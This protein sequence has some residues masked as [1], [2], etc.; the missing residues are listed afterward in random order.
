MPNP[1]PNHVT[2]DLEKRI[3]AIEALGDV[4]LGKFTKW[5]WWLCVVGAG[6]CMVFSLLLIR[7]L[8]NL[9]N[10]LR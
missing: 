8:K 4:E 9:M 7:Q 1:T 6:L 2:L 3:E 10:L 5:D